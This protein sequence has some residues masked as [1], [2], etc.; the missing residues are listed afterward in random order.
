MKE[1]KANRLSLHR[2]CDIKSTTQLSGDLLQTSI[3]VTTA[4]EVLQ[5]RDTTHVHQYTSIHAN[6]LVIKTAYVSLT[7]QNHMWQTHRKG[8]ADI[9]EVSQATEISAS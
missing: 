7:K 9:M 2:Q 8:A 4:P 6:A 5:Q 3:H 1:E